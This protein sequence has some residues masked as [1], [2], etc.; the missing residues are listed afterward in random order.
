MC[1]KVWGDMLLQR[2]CKIWPIRRKESEKE[3]VRERGRGKGKGRGTNKV[4]SKVKSAGE[5]GTG[6]RTRGTKSGRE[7]RLQ[8]Y[9]E[10]TKTPN[11]MEQRTETR[12]ES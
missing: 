5:R 11:G 4:E 6:G 12:I 3:R 7:P 1:I 2:A 8:G 10:T 9:T